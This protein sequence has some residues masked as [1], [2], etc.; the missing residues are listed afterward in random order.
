MTCSAGRE[1]DAE[2]AEKVMGW[3]GIGQWSCEI[4]PDDDDWFGVPPGAIEKFKSNE[5][6]KTC[7]PI[8]N[9]STDIAAA[10]LVFEKLSQSELTCSTGDPNDGGSHISYVKSHPTKA[11]SVVYPVVERFG[12]QFW[13][14]D[15]SMIGFAE[16][17]TAPL[18]I[19]LAALMAVST[20]S[21]SP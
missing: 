20:P 17:D 5:L 3:T 11:A 8:P 15:G 18:A 2:V 9:Y 13:S 7:W 16:A 12:C 14:A 10:W 21:Q 19:C 6:T 1:L 4:V